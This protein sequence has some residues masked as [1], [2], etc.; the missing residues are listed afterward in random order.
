MAFTNET[1]KPAAK[2]KKQMRRYI[3]S[4]NCELLLRRGFHEPVKDAAGFVL[5][6]VW[7]HPVRIAF[8]NRNFDTDDVDIQTMLEAHNLWGSEFYWH[9]TMEGHIEGFDKDIAGRFNDALLRH[10]IQIRKGIRKAAGR[11]GSVEDDE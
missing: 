1:S 4:S 6:T 8:Q 2:P 3:A 9:P 11:R 10:R 7:K 5:S